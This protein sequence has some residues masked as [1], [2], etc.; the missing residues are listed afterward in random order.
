MNSLRTKDIV[1][2]LKNNIEPIEDKFYGKGYRATAYLTDGTCL[3][4]VEF[5]SVG[6]ITN[7]AIRRFK[8]ELSGK[9]I[10]GK[11]SG[12]GYYEIV[13]SFVAQGNCVN[14]YSIAKVEKSKYA[15]PLQI[16]KQIKGETSMG[17]TGF[18]AKMKDGNIF[19]FG[20]DFHFSFFEMP[21]D[22]HSDDIIEIINHSYIGSDGEIK[23]HHEFNPNP[24][25]SIQTVFRSKPFFECF[26]D[27]L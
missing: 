9:S 17:W 19:A 8:E 5:R 11:S 22:Y 7:L 24:D 18:V 3:P 27:D 15:F 26:M 2:F 14:D 12:L 16:I 10:F 20:T 6:N 23:S 25:L 4:C 1:Q 13:K 21:P